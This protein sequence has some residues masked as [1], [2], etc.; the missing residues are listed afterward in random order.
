MTTLTLVTNKANI[1]QTQWLS[2]EPVPLALGQARLAVEH[3]AFT[4]NN[5]TYAAFGEAMKYW[6]FF[7]QADPAWGCVPVWGYARVTESRCEGVEL[8]AR[9]YGYYPFANELVVQPTRAT[10]ASFVDGMPNRAELHAL[11]NQYLN[12]ALDPT[13]HPK[14]EAHT[15][16][17]RPLFITSFLIDDFF[18][19]SDW[20]GAKTLVLSSASSKTAYG[21]A[22][23]LASR[24]RAERPEI[25]GLTSSANLAFTQ[26]LGL[27]DRVLTYDQISQLDAAA[28]TAY[29][30]F[31]GSAPV[32]SAIH[33]HCKGLAF[34]SAIG[35]THWQDFKTTH[36]L[37]GPRPT[38]FFAPAQ[39]KKRL[40]DWG[41]A[42]FQKRLGASMMGFLKAVQNP[43]APWMSVEQHRGQAAAQT[44]YDAVVGGKASAEAGYMVTL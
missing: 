38:L 29:V 34:S 22:Y 25:V 32:R 7:P 28:P 35:G 19:D 24:P 4:A 6:Q 14:M 11:Y 41:P 23:A 5:V 40:A 18:A 13:Y 9:F 26:R 37:P 10:P 30:D 39:A 33:A 17:L 20:F 16:L 27:Y 12:V 3:F 15:S 44:V 31:S 21:T 36:D 8:G 42:E 1:T 2:A 43:A